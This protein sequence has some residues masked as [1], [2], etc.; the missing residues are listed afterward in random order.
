M[1]FDHYDWSAAAFCREYMLPY[2][3]F[4]NWRRER[5]SLP[6][7]GTCD[8][9]GEAQFVE[10]V[11]Q[12]PAGQ[13]YRELSP[14]PVPVRRGG[15]DADSL[16]HPLAH[17]GSTGSTGSTVAARAPGEV[18]AELE[19]GSDYVLRVFRCNAT[20]TGAQI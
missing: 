15:W 14:K 20:S 5:E 11:P 19:L 4:L 17:R 7:T 2:G 8:G 13:Q 12:Q 10:L 3:S 18:L 9:G 16:N 1:L 6:D